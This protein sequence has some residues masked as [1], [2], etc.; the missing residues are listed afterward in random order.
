M[1]FGEACD[2]Y[3]KYKDSKV[4]RIDDIERFELIESLMKQMNC[5]TTEELMKK[6]GK[7]LSDSKKK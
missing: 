3:N 5:T 1:R 7:K 2:R 6:M 4:R